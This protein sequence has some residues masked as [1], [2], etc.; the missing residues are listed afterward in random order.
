[1][2][3]LF[4]TLD[5]VHNFWILITFFWLLVTCFIIVY[6]VG[7]V[8]IILALAYI[9]GSS[10]QRLAFVS[11]PYPCLHFSAFCSTVVGFFFALFN[12]VYIYHLLST[13]SKFCLHFSAV[14]LHF[15][16]ISTFVSCW[17]TLVS[18]LFTFFS[19]FGLN[20]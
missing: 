4:T 7:L 13:F 2:W 6:I 20:L 11:I 12:L 8:F 5:F 15:F 19:L 14:C 17:L 3:I 10:L 9:F 1:M 16:Y 18:H